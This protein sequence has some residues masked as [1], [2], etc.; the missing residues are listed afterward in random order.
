MLFFSSAFVCASMCMCQ[1]SLLAKSVGL[2]KEND[3]SPFYIIQFLIGFY[4]K[5]S[6]LLCF[7]SFIPFSIPFLSNILIRMRNEVM[8]IVQHLGTV[9]NSAVK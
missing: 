4:P 9:G 8:K 2:L 1:L 3:K 5:L 6:P 7:L